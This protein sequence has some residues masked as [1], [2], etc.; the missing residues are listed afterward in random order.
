MR[1]LLKVGKVTNH[2][3][4]TPGGGPSL[5]LLDFTLL[6]GN[7]LFQSLCVFLSPVPPQCIKYSLYLIKLLGK[8]GG[9]H[10]S[11]YYI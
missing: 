10:E 5:L 2:L 3:K 6:C 11:Y 7:S 9:K 1:T 8:E 4:R